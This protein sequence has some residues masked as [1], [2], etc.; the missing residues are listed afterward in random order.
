MKNIQAAG[1]DP[2]YSQS[3]KNIYCGREI[4]KLLKL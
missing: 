2:L 4:N 3:L 1:A